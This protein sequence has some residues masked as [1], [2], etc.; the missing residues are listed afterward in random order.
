MSKSNAKAYSK[1]TKEDTRKHVRRTDEA[2]AIAKQIMGFVFKR[3]EGRVGAAKAD[4]QHE[5]KV[6]GPQPRSFTNQKPLSK[7]RGEPAEEK[8]A[9]KIDEKRTPRECCA[10]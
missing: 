3:R 5:S 10:K 6:I 1:K 2:I 8:A 4:G 9:C 7:N